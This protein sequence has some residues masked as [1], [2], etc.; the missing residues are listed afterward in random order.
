VAVVERERCGVVV[1]VADGGGD[2]RGGG[3]VLFK[4]RCAIVGQVSRVSGSRRERGKAGNLG[5]WSHLRG[6]SSATRVP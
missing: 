1:V 5:K 3:V 4:D 6:W 2:S